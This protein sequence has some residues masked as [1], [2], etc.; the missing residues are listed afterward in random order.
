[1]LD[2][3]KIVKVVLSC[4]TVHEICLAN[5]DDTVEFLEDG[6]EEVNNF[7]DIVNLDN[8]GESKRRDIMHLLT[9]M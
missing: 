9:E 3:A 1:M 8:A 6:P 5:Q 7:Q 4:C 2:I